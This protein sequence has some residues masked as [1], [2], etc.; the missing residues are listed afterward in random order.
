VRLGVTKKNA[1]EGGSSY[2]EI[3]GLHAKDLEGGASNHRR[4]ST[5][6]H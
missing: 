3:S 1:L 6:K 5:K 4:R 2:F